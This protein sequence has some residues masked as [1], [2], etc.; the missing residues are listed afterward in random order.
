MTNEV[1]TQPKKKYADV[2]NTYVQ[3]VNKKLDLLAK[4][5]LYCVNPS[6][7]NRVIDRF[8]RLDKHLKFIQSNA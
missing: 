4:K 5:A 8:N 1:N 2:S 3:S 7:I 6:N